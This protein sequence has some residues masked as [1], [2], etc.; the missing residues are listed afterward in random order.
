ME[1]IL[2]EENNEIKENSGVQENNEVKENNENE[3]NLEKEEEEE[4]IDPIELEKQKKEL[5]LKEANEGLSQKNYL[6]A[7]EKYSSIIGTENKEYLENIKDKMVE[8]LFNYSLSLYYQ[9]KYESAAK[10]IYDI[11]MNYDNKHK[12]AYLLLIK[13]LCDIKEYNRAKLLY[14]KINKIFDDM[15]EFNEINDD[16]NNYFKI[17]NNNIQRQF[18]Y[19]AEKEI[20]NFRKK[21]NFFYWCFYSFG[22]L[23]IGHYLSK[24]LL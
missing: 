16:I 4:E 23:I 24:L 7:E 22:A 19:N 11:I 10:N 6:K 8:I 3:I 17:K 18:Y 2:S 13:I 1:N 21:L 20:F 9:M 15:T 12:E 5:L 14:E